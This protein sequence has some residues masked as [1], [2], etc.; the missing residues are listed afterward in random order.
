MH[1]NEVKMERRDHSQNEMTTG[2]HLGPLFPKETNVHPRGRV[3]LWES[4]TVEK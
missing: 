3:N 2:V 1:Q 4:H